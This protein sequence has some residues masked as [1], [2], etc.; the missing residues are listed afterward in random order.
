MPDWS[1]RTLLQTVASGGALA[2]SG[3]S[4]QTRGFTKDTPVYRRRISGLETTYV[5][6]EDGE[7]LFVEATGGTTD[8]IGDQPGDDRRSH[9][10]HY[11]TDEREI[12]DFRFRDVDGAADLRSAVGATDFETKSVF[13][14]QRPIGA[15]YEPRLVGVYREGD[16][17]DA[18]FCQD[19]RPADVA[20][21]ADAMDV[22]AVAIRLPL[23]G[24]D[25]NSLGTGFSGRCDHE[26]SS[27]LT[28]GGEQS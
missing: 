18:D 22:F 15:C 28:E 12:E 27:P 23:A 10:V 2:L 3:C 4:G 5:R 1:R 9:Q 26:V 20:C 13:L 14:L 24:D 21:D 8:D 25:F 19:L 17:V 6:N 7:P 11:L 16:G